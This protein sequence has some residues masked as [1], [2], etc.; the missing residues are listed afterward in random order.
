MNDSQLYKDLSQDISNR[1]RQD[2]CS[3]ELSSIQSFMDNIN[4][5]YIKSKKNE[6]SEFKTVKK[7]LKVK[8]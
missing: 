4:D 8:I 2:E 6:M 3:P 1:Y 5:E 7:M